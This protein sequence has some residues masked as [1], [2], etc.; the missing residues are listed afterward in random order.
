MPCSDIADSI[1]LL[2]RQTLERAIRHIEGSEVWRA[3][4]IYGDTDS[5]FIHLPGRTKEEAFKIAKEMASVITA[6]NPDPVVLKF[7]KVY[8]PCLMITKKRYVGYS[9]EAP[10]QQVPVFDAKGI[11]T[12]RRDQCAATAR[13]LESLIRCLFDHSG[14]LTRLKTYF[15]EQVTKILRHDINPTDVIIRR[16]VKLGT[17]AKDSTLPPAARVALKKIQ[18]DSASAPLYGE[19][20]PY[21]VLT[22]GSHNAGSDKLMDLVED[23]LCV[24]RR[25][26]PFAIHGDHYMR[27][28]I[29]PALERV[30][31]L[32]GVD[33]GAWYQTMPRLLSSK[34]HLFS[35]DLCKWIPPGLAEVRAEEWSASRTAVFDC[36]RDLVRFQQRHRKSG[37]G[38]QS[39]MTSFTQSVRCA[40]CG[41]GKSHTAPSMPPVCAACLGPDALTLAD[42]VSRVM[43]RRKAV[44]GELQR[45]AL[46]CQQC[47]W[48][49]PA[50]IEDLEEIAAQVPHKKDRLDIPLA[51]DRCSTSAPI[52]G[53]CVSL[54]C[55][56]TFLLVR[57]R[58]LLQQLHVLEDFLLRGVASS[59]GTTAGKVALPAPAAAKPPPPSSLAAAFGR[60]AAAP[61][62]G[63]KDRPMEID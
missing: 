15:T 47:T 32:V 34:S 59:S 21:V 1:V 51:I 63:G 44:E 27:K 58:E 11:E 62:I 43:F 49:R 24:L 13:V 16:E 48:S 29:L 4:V 19:R 61:R 10:Q 12:I 46:R 25:D 37:G 54:E 50:G 53:A 22:G 8:Q 28:H 18:R 31:H 3:K 5:L 35:V 60:F 17:Y 52:L 56:Q 30:F 20:V 7:E 2:G 9:W 14:D 6:S 57:V 41:V 23:P 45:V 33:F 38:V 40:V 42:S 26:V 36:A 55:S 39:C